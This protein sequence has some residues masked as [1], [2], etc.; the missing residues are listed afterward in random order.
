MKTTVRISV[1]NLVEFILRSGDLDSRSR[2]GADPEAML[3][4]AKIHRKIQKER[5]GGYE[6]EVSLS[7]NLEFD[8]L[9]IRVEGRAD[10]LIRG[11]VPLIEEIKGVYR[12]LEQMEGPDGVHLAQAKCYAAMLLHF[13]GQASARIRMTYV[14][15]ESDAVRSFEETFS[16]EE[17]EAWFR[18]VAER[19]YAWALLLQRHREARNA[20][21]K[22]L[23][24]PFPY[25]EGQR[26]LVAAVYRVLHDQRILF[27]EAP[28][29]VGKTMSVVF[30]S[31]RS[32]GEGCGERVFYLTSKTITRTVGLEA[33]SILRAAGLTWKLV[34]ITAKEKI[35]PM[36]EVSCNPDDCPYAKGHFDRINEAVFSLLQRESAF[37][38]ETVAR[39]AREFTV[40]PFELSLDLSDWVDAVICDYNYAFDPTVRLKR[41]F[42]DGVKS[43]AILLVDEAHNLV[44]RAREM[45]SASLVKEHVLAAKRYFKERSP[46]AAKSLEKV[47][48][49]LLAEKKRC[50]AEPDLTGRSK[51]ERCRLLP[52]VDEYVFSLMTASERMKAYFEEHPSDD[53]EVTEFYFEVLSFLSASERITEKYECCSHL[54]EEGFAVKINCVDPSSDLQERLDQ[55]YA[56]VFFSATL[57]P[58]QYYRRHLTEKEDAPAVYAESPFDPANRCVLIGRDVT[59]RYRARSGQMYDTI[60]RWIRI[61]AGAQKGNYIAFFP[62][63][64]MMEEVLRIYREKYDSPGINWVAQARWM[65]E[66]DREMF[67]ENFAEDPRETLVAFCVMG[68]IFAEGIDLIGSRLIGAVVV[69]TGLPQVGCEKELLRSAYD[70]RGEDGFGYAYRVPGMNRVLQAAGRVI[71]TESD[72]GVIVLLDDRFLHAEYQGMFPLEWKERHVCRAEDAE[73]ALTEFWSSA[74]KDDTIE[75][76]AEAA[77]PP[78]SGPAAKDGMI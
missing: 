56:A 73:A 21:A 57:L 61:T 3:L 51:E 6:S 38:R 33:F 22:A 43:G 55:A 64:Q 66:E 7:Q 59:T 16:A 17:L 46:R 29:G 4:G 48:R 27:V 75:T 19:Y 24:F 34:V 15:L 28:T 8:E 70:K 39:A 5:G 14:Q 10:G 65:G 41:F 40:C 23:E 12:D 1:R 30:P 72:R 44:D 9:T 26:K 62:S 25:R 54:T 71:R 60:A 77:E 67:L 76:A 31:V 47:N 45:F 2:A 49:L 78:V 32:V 20:S 11:E 69:G 35:C 18:S 37:D 50:E 74:E 13:E 68:G 42:A 63:Y 53:P 58:V 52:D 36:S